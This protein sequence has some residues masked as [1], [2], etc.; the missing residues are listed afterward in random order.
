MA[1]EDN[2]RPDNE[3]GDPTGGQSGAFSA[4]NGHGKKTGEEQAAVNRE[5]DPPA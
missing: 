3:D 1:V 4:P 5:D 2:N